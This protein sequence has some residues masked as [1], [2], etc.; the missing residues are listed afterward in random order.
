MPRYAYNTNGMTNHRLDGALSLIADS[1]YD[2][3]ALT[4]DHHHLD[5]F[6]PELSRRVD[7]LS[8][9]LAGLQLGLVV[10]TGAPYLLD[11]RRAH[12]PTLVSPEPEGRALRLEFLTRALDVAAACGAE[13]VP[14]R[15]G[16]PRPDVEPREAWEYLQQGLAA[17]AERAAA[18]GVVAA[19]AP[20][21]GMFVETVGDYRHVGDVVPGLRLALDIGRLVVTDEG[22]PGAVIRDVAPE[23]GIVTIADARRGVWG[24][25]PFGEGDLDVPA[26]LRAFLDVD[27]TRLV[28]VELARDSYRAHAMVGDALA[29][30]KTAERAVTA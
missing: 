5:P 2:G 20:E 15:T 14:F 10:E 25:L 30:L 29:Y 3:V 19:L 22:D 9:R 7:A 18:R 24:A 16:A 23:L 27:Y 21:P 17:I 8:A 12:E 6:A 1:G 13:A 26:A 11:P 4:L 28:C